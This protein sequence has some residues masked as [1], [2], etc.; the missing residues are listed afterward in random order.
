MSRVMDYLEFDDSLAI[1]LT[2]SSPL[3]HLLCANGGWRVLHIHPAHYFGCISRWPRL[4]LGKLSGLRSLHISPSS[5]ARLLPLLKP[6]L[7][8]I[9]S[10]SRLLTDLELGFVEAL[11]DDSILHLPASL[12]RL[13]LPF[14]TRISHQGLAKLPKGLLALNLHRNRLVTDANLLPRQ[15]CHYVGHPSVMTPCLSTFKGL[16]P[17]LDRLE[18]IRPGADDREK[19]TATPW[20]V[21]DISSLN[22]PY[23]RHL[24]LEVVADLSIS[25]NDREKTH[26][27]S[28]PPL[29]ETLRLSGG[30]CS[31]LVHPCIPALP[32]SLTKLKMTSNT[33]VSLDWTDE[34][35]ALLPRTLKHLELFPTAQRRQTFIF[36]GETFRF[37]AR[38]SGLK[39]ALD[40]QELLYSGAPS[41]APV[42]L[43]VACFSLIPRCMHT[44]RI[45]ILGVPT[46]TWNE[47]FLR[48]NSPDRLRSDMLSADMDLSMEEYMQCLPP[49]ITCLWAY[50][51][52][53]PPKRSSIRIAALR[54]SLPLHL[55]SYLGSISPYDSTHLKEPLTGN[56]SYTKLPKLHSTRLETILHC[57]EDHTLGT[58]VPWETN[59]LLWSDGL[60]K[61][62]LSRGFKGS[63]G[64]LTRLVN[65]THLELQNVHIQDEDFLCLPNSLVSLKVHAPR[66]KGVLTDQ[67]IPALP[68]DLTHL[69][70]DNVSV[71]GDLFPLPP[72][73]ITYHC[74]YSQ[75]V[76]YNQK[77]APRGPIVPL[78]PRFVTTLLLKST[79]VYGDDSF[80]SLPN[81]LTRLEVK[82]LNGRTFPYLP[83]SLLEIESY[84][85]DAFD[86]D[87][88]GLPRGLMSFKGP[89][90]GHDLSDHSA[91]DWPRRL[92]RL[93]LAVT[94]FSDE[95]LK[96]L[97]RG[98]VE[99]Y[100][101][102]AR[103]TT[104]RHPADVDLLLGTR[105]K[106][107]RIGTQMTEL[108]REGARIE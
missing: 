41:D 20:T 14:N 74:T 22:A 86:E 77:S 18:L 94:N 54:Y 8:N 27:W 53:G 73:L 82:H 91:P 106:S 61:L 47:Q 62:R 101:V 2:G 99:V 4:L 12:T 107:V 103:Y 25:S 13:W 37:R 30:G 3:L 80:M 17:F 29:L 90:L 72:K 35:M 51:C 6:D 39:A 19:G 70:L 5:P 34:D 97:P 9:F 58:F 102:A 7:H 43:S 100:L 76:F 55:R 44:L 49:S 92:Y 56:S 31:N 81:T 60:Q 21:F 89:Y 68:Q 79:A 108:I 38:H 48:N 105:W 26:K 93:Q 59:Q 52:I 45:E 42:G 63:F 28:F 65:L 11:G 69:Q 67:L 64:D 75:D 57:S 36:K 98:L 33:T 78:L 24:H 83:R 32:S 50:Q 96:Q 15:I 40:S 16:P 87:I 88:A 23:L 1:Y 10:L 95:G 46:K 84:T 85:G 71:I 104:C 66:S